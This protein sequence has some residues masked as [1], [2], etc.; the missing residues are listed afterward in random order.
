MKLDTE[1]DVLEKLDKVEEK[2]LENEYKSGNRNPPFNIILDLLRKYTGLLFSVSI[3]VLISQL[4]GLIGLLTIFG[5]SLF[6]SLHSYFSGGALI[7]R[8]YSALELKE[9][10]Y[11][12]DVKK[13]YQCFVDACDEI[14]LEPDDYKIY[15]GKIGRANAFI[16]YSWGDDVI[17]VSNSLIEKVTEDE[18]KSILQHELGHT[19]ISNYM[20]L[21]ILF[22]GI[23]T[24]FFATS[25]FLL[26]F[27]G[28][29]LFVVL[30]LIT[31]FLNILFT[32]FQGNEE[33]KAD[34]IVSSG[35]RVSLSRSLIK[36]K[37][38]SYHVQNKLFYIFHQLLDPHPPINMRSS[39]EFDVD[40]SYSLSYI[41]SSLSKFF[42]ICF[43]LTL[44]LAA[45]SLNLN[46]VG[47]ELLSVSYFFLILSTAS[48]NLGIK[49]FSGF[50]K[51]I[52]AVP[53]ISLFLYAFGFLVNLIIGLEAG[54]FSYIGFGFIYIIIFIW[55]LLIILGVSVSTN[56]YD[57]LPSL[58]SYPYDYEDSESE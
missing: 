21:S 1:I 33:R 10:T 6:T 46:Y 52:I 45:L 2:R 8:I 42:S 27:R 50:I 55:I 25:F 22:S 40:L 57:D 36:M 38:E 17:I 34:N 18:L 44:T 30:S 12:E 56:S 5:I 51:A 16:H 47:S 31:I 41:R 28:L 35:L 13:V 19:F 54:L 29:E 26:G 4:F 7:R 23:S 32:L 15:S 48:S 9:K 24:S 43:I 53:I 14:G 49:S 11:N 39:V 3:F 37:K 20:V 58:L